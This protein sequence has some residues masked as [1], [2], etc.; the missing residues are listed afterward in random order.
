M[1]PDQPKTPTLDP[2]ILDERQ[3]PDRFLYH[4]LVHD[5]SPLSSI[6]GCP[7]IDFGSKIS[8]EVIG[9]YYLP[10]GRLDVVGQRGEEGVEKV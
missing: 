2:Q 9:V 3:D 6:P 8:K 7:A 10:R 5:P 1:N 4:S